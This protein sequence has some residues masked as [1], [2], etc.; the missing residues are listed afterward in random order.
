MRYRR[1]RRRRPR[2]RRSP[3]PKVRPSATRRH[4]LKDG[5]RLNG[6]SATLN[7]SLR[8]QDFANPPLELGPEGAMGTSCDLA[9]VFG[10]ASLA[11]RGYRETGDWAAD[12]W[13]LRTGAV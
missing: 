9:D 5:R 2:G 10:R 1:P 13:D 12:S 3:P 11:P 4:S 6:P 7:A 8:R